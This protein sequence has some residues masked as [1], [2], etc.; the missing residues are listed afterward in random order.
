MTWAKRQAL[1][2]RRTA[3]P[4]SGAKSLAATVGTGN[5]AAAPIP[6]PAPAAA[7]DAA[8]PPA[9]APRHQHFSYSG[10]L[11]SS[12]VVLNLTFDSP[13]N[14]AKVPYAWTLHRADAELCY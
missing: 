11:N 1:I 7:P 9:A 8:L 3:E 5:P 6:L 10:P 12:V 14:A 4:F 13:D 2:R